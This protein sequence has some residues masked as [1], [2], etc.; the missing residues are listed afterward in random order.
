[1]GGSKRKND[2]RKKHTKNTKGKNIM[3]FIT[4]ELYGESE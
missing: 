1:M 2:L 4:K 3:I